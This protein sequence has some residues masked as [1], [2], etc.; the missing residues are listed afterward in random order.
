MY[1]TGGDFCRQYTDNTFETELPSTPQYVNEGKL[2]EV[3]VESGKTYYFLTRGLSKGELTVTFGEKATP[4]EL[5]SLSKEEGTTLNLSID[6]L[7]GFTFNR[8]VKVGNCTL[9][10]DA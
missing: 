4:L 8:M 10:F 7:L 2:V 3:K 9:S 5:L 6:T 1:Q